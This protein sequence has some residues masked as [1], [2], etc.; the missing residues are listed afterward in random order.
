MEH[1][2]CPSIVDIE[3]SGFGEESYPIEIGIAKDSGER[4]CALIKPDQ[5]WVYWSGPAETIHGITREMI[6]L[7]GR[8]THQICE[9]LNDFLGETNVFT[10][11]LAHD[12]AWLY[13]LFSSAKLQP[14]FHLRAIEFIMSEEQFK[15]WDDMKSHVAQQL[16]IV[17]HRASSDA[18]LIQQTFIQSKM[19]LRSH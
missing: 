5:G 9:E 15:I 12:Q 19:R 16:Q 7:R 3:A 4:Y 1:V 10:D 18:F 13:K 17:R 8:P 14:S 6:E 2:Q 11:A